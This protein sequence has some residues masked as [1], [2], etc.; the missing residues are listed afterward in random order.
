[1]PC[2][3]N[4]F[5]KSFAEVQGQ[6]GYKRV[7]TGVAIK[8]GESGQPADSVQI[9]WINDVFGGRKGKKEMEGEIEF[10]KTKFDWGH[11]RELPPQ[12]S[13]KYA[14]MDFMFSYNTAE[15]SQDSYCR[16]VNTDTIW[17]VLGEKRKGGEVRAAELEPAIEK[18][19]EG[20]LELLMRNIN[21]VLH[22][23][24]RTRPN[25]RVWAD[26][27]SCHS[28]RSCRRIVRVG[29][30]II[31][32]LKKKKEP[33][34][35]RAL[36]RLKR[37]MLAIMPDSAYSHK[38]YSGSLGWLIYLIEEGWTPEKALELVNP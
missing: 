16:G 1:M 24:V 29:I 28:T 23:M 30:R 3:E 13:I 2:S 17:R 31:E 37:M 26:V 14:G 32:M 19:K 20:R 18:E 36:N 33:L 8:V 35:M 15:I 27:L 11:L 21:G 5:D 4:I 7:E 12:L 34:R 22:W 9:N 38:T 6:A 25:R 10:L